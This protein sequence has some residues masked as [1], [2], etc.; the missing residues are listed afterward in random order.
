M[1]EV[2]IWFNKID[3]ANIRISEWIGE[4]PRKGEFIM[5]KLTTY[6]I[7]NIIW[8]IDKSI[9]ILVVE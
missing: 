3:K 7:K 4:L 2:E 6:T 8:D 9:V 5:V 1:K